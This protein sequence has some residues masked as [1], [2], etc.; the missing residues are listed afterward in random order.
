MDDHLTLSI[1]IKRL[2]DIKKK[3]LNEIGDREEGIE[4]G[5]FLDY[6]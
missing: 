4:Q 2:W 5:V 3:K 1:N 6:A